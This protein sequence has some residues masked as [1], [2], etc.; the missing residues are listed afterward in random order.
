MTRSMICRLLR[1]DDRRSAFVLAGLILTL[2]LPCH[3]V[4]ECRIE[5]VSVDEAGNPGDDLSGYPTINA[6]GRYVA[7]H[8]YATNLVP[9]DTNRTDDVFVRDRV[10]GVTKRV[11]VDSAGQEALGGS[12]FPSMS[13]DG[14][15]VA[16]E[17]Y[18]ANLVPD[19]RNVQLDIFVHDR[20][21]GS[22]ERVNVSTAGGETDD[23]SRGAKLSADGRFVAFESSASNLDEDDN[24][25]R[26]ETMIGDDFVFDLNCNDVFV[27]DRSA[28]ATERV[29]V[30]PTGGQAHGNSENAA[31]SGEGRFVAFDSD[32]PD[33][34]LGDTDACA[35]RFGSR[36]NCRDVFVRDRVTGITER[37]SVSSS[38]REGNG[39]S[40]RPTISADGRFV[41]FLSYANTLVPDDPTD[42][43]T[44][45]A[46]L[47]DRLTGRTQ[48]APGASSLSADGRYLV[49]DSADIFA[50]DRASGQTR[51]VSRDAG[52]NPGSAFSFDPTISADG[53]SVAFTSAAEN[54]AA[55]FGDETDAGSR[56]DIF[57]ATGCTQA[58]CVGDCD[59][60]GSVTV[61]EL[62]EGVTIALASLPPAACES[63]D[64]NGDQRVTV[65][66]LV[67][68]V[69][70]ALLGCH[71]ANP[72]PIPY[73]L[74]GDSGITP[75][76]SENVERLDGTFV[77]IPEEPV[78]PNAE[79]RFV[80]RTVRFRSQAAAAV[81]HA[82][83]GTEGSLSSSLLDPTTISVRLTVT[84]NGEAVELTGIATAQF[85]PPSVY[86]TF[87]E[88]H[89]TGGGYAVVL[90]AIPEL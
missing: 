1:G 48:R 59:H 17:S 60:D 73:R 8:S 54:L 26:C 7:F 14:R 78:V 62:V 35:G 32:A 16:F 2:L 47:H 22:T 10:A 53:Q 72:D 81:A 80:V 43:L 28:D 46:F 3:A 75:P 29:S 58:P 45:K 38:G 64:Q 90:S 69:N 12:L 27:H 86:P 56:D 9:G 42:T 39:D 83:D 49:F 85:S 6:D 52:G 74:L 79:L 88:M 50:L 87:T 13:A 23:V 66:E 65:D 31:I 51:L 30:D 89:L 61:D 63:F 11:S 84:I 41:A 24:T 37:V 71:E 55:P 67:N 82:V 19:D 34:V 15:F 68:G 44:L 20:L 40:F 77:V 76:G 25:A 36:R 57:V 5:R 33:L 21:T 4:A 18:A 70:G